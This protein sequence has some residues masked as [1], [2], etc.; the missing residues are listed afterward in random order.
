MDSSLYKTVTTGRDLKYNYY[1][2]APTAGKPVILFVHGFPNTSNDWRHQVAFFKAHG[3]GIIVPDLLGYGGTDKPIDYTQYR[4][5]AIVRDVID[6]LDTEKVEKAIAIG[7]DWGSILVSRL[8]NYHP[9]RFIAFG[10]LA[11][12]YAAPEDVTFE[13]LFEIT[14]S[15]AGRELFGYWLFFNEDQAHQIIEKNIDSFYSLLVAEDAELWDSDFAPTSGL[16]TWVEADKRTT[17]ASYLTEEEVNDHK[18]A[19][20][21][22]GLQAPLNWYRVRVRGL[23]VQDIKGE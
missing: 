10:F 11:A 3:Y 20:L 12:G 7:H 2:S 1:Y 21:Q 16:R 14:K 5:S 17:V 9:D 6:I 4:L 15:F 19:L 8:A 23:D 18:R 13:Q 22:G